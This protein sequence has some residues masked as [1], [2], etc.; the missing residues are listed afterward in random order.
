M[1]LACR[2]LRPCP[3]CS[4]GQLRTFTVTAISIACASF[5]SCELHK[6]KRQVPTLAIGRSCA[7]V[8]LWTCG[9]QPDLKN[10]MKA[11]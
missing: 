6:R 7:A 4:V 5:C 10:V 11:S 8:D 2:Q 1:V 3:T 9:L